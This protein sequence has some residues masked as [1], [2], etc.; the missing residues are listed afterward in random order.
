MG[1]VEFLDCDNE[2]VL[3]FRRHTET[4]SLL[5]LANLASTARHATVKLPAHAGRPLRDVF[6]G[7]QFGTVG[8]DG[9]AT[10]TLGSREFFWLALG[11]PPELG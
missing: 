6:G 10:F 1:E 2:S 5:V 4:E 11:D 9:T 7:A 8:D 3:A